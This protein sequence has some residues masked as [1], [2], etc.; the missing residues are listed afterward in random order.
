LPQDVVFAADSIKTSWETEIMST[1]LAIEAEQLAKRYE[2][3]NG[4]VVEAV[5]G[6]NLTIP[7]GEIY[8]ILGHGRLGAHRRLRC[9]ASIE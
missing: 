6:V 5:R 9:R 1:L 4:E 7:Q 2:T 8:A 3:S